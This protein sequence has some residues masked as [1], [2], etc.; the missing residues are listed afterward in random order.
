MA[1]VRENSTALYTIFRRRDR[2][3]DT[4]TGPVI[5]VGDVALLE[6][7]DEILLEDGTDSILLEA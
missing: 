1:R 5:E 6:I 4:D 2:R 3:A 7:G